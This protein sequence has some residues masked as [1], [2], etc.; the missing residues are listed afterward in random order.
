MAF[1]AASPRQA[2]TLAW[3]ALAGA[4]VMGQLGALLGLPQWLMNLSPFAHVQ[5]VSA[6]GVTARPMWTLLAVAVALAVGA[7]V[8]FRRRD[9]VIGA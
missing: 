8:A 9:L 4:L 1:A 3:A 5:A 7:A 2:G 6:E